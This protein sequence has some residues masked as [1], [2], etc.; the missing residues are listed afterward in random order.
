MIT[1][2]NKC[3]L[4]NNDK[5]KLIISFGKVPLGNNLQDKLSESLKV[6][7]YKLNL[8]RCKNMRHF[9]LG[10]LVD[11][12]LLYATNYTYLSGVTKT[13]LILF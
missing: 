8:N 9:Q 13:F 1:K 6:S 4:C 11:K 5:V 3:R 7:S 2:I 12:K 10:Y